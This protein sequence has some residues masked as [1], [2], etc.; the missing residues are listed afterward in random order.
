MVAAD[1]LLGG[2][3]HADAAGDH[4][5]SNSRWPLRGGVVT[6]P[7]NCVQAC[8]SMMKR[9]RLSRKTEETNLVD[10]HVGSRVRMRRE[11][12]GMSQEKLSNALGLTAQQTHNMRA[13]KTASAPA[14]FRIC[15]MSS[16]AAAIN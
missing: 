6:M 11:M 3:V 8:G 2:P 16:T 4:V 1:R 10:K 12:L 14:D 15:P 13:E 7:R 9:E 5:G